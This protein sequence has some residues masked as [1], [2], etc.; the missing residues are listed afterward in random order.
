M[1]NS[2]KFHLIECDK[3]DGTGQNYAPSVRELLRRW[4][5]KLGITARA[6]ADHLKCDASAFS[7][8]E[9]GKEP[10][11][12][13]RL[14]KYIRFLEYFESKLEFETRPRPA[15]G[16]QKENM[17][18][19]KTDAQKETDGVDKDSEQ[20]PERMLKWFEFEVGGLPDSVGG[21]GNMFHKLAENICEDIQ[22][23]PERTVALRKLLEAKD[24]AVRA[25]LN[26]GG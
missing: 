9:R 8:F 7:R 10:F 12:Q 11:G 3:C 26:P 25:K 4:R 22:G 24:A 1:K 17:T 18:E 15:T 19:V 23:G 20:R 16:R 2:L 6:V 5:K 14:R 13:P 21:I